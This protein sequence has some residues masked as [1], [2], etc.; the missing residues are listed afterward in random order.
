MHYP[1]RKPH[2][3]QRVQL[4]QKLFSRNNWNN[5]N[6]L[7]QLCGDAFRRENS[8]QQASPKRFSGHRK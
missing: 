7:A 5:A 4:T 6:K 8:I 1:Y 3:F 2:S